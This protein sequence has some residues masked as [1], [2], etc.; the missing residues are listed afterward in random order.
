[1]AWL[2][3]KS[4]ARYADVSPRLVR[5]WLQQGLRHSRPNQK[6][7]LIRA[8]DL[9]AFLESHKVESNKVER[10]VKDLERDLL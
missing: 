6:L 2:R 10:C 1:M 5:K 7:V 4:A 9:D 3:V 8:Q